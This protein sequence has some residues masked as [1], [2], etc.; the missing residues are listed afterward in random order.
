MKEEYAELKL[1]AENYPAMVA[2]DI[3]A[4]RTGA[5]SQGNA[6]PT[7]QTVTPAT[8]TASTAHSRQALNRIMARQ[9]SGT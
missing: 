6:Q 9:R 2:E 5:T 1:V 7:Q 8:P 3:A 4:A